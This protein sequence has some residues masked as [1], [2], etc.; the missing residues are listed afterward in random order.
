ML[1]VPGNGLICAYSKINRIH[2]YKTVR[3]RY[4]FLSSNQYAAVHWKTERL[5]T[6]VL[7]NLTHRLCILLHIFLALKKVTLEKQVD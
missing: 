1:L 2:I 5:I 7:K 3:E 6:A 4:F